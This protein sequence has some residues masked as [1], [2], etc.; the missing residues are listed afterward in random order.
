MFIQSEEKDSVQV[1]QTRR[2]ESRGYCV[3]QRHTGHRDSCKLRKKTG[4]SGKPSGPQDKMRDKR[5]LGA[6]R[7]WVPLKM[8]PCPWAVGSP[9]TSQVSPDQLRAAVSRQMVCAGA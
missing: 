9:G 4:L 2:K 1:E 8:N 6:G 5:F 7:E 3:E